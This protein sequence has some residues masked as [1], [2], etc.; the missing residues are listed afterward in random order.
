MA[1]LDV[2]VVDDEWL[3]RVALRS[4]LDERA[5]VGVVREAD[6]V[7]S[8]VAALVRAP[9]VV[10][11]DVR[12]LDESGFELF[13][14]TDVRVP[15]VFVTAYGDY[16]VRAFAVEAVDYLVKPVLR[17]HLDRALERVWRRRDEAPARVSLR[18]GK[19][20]FFAEAAEIRFVRADGD[21]SEVHLGDGRE[22]RVKESLES[23]QSRLPPCFAR[24]H[25][26][27]LANLDAAEG[28]VAS[29]GRWELRLRDVAAPLP[30]SRRLAAGL[31]ER[32]G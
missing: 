4:L 20:V 14:R 12:L 2:L 24:I 21:Y 8:A 18:A 15:V 31:R 19:S 22:V 1:K 5:D 29:G 16:A 13:E 11:L 10:F 7:A 28:L 32:L 25:R 9:D 17:E 27:L 30:V 23:W 3:A 6:S 26:S